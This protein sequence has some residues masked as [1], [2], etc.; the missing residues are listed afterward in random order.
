MVRRGRCAG[1]VDWRHLALS[2]CHGRHG[3]VHADAA[4]RTAVTPVPQRARLTRV[5]RI[6]RR[7]DVAARDVEAERAPAFPR[8]IQF[9]E[10]FSNAINLKF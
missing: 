7:A 9:A 1:P 8:Q 5:R 2:T 6:R 4:Q 3:G 10:R